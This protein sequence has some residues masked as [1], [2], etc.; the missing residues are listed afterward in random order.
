MIT[1]HTVP[2]CLTALFTCLLILA[3]CG[4]R[5]SNLDLV[6]VEEVEP[7][8]QQVT[9]VAE[10]DTFELE[11]DEPWRRVY[12]DQTQDW[13]PAMQNDA[14][15]WVLT[16]EGEA[17]RQQRMEELQ[18]REATMESLGDWR[19]DMTDV[20]MRSGALAAKETPG[21]EAKPDRRLALPEPSASDAA[22]A[23]P[24]P[25]PN[26]DTMD[27][28][29]TADMVYTA[30][31]QESVDAAIPAVEPPAEAATDPTPTLAPDEAEAIAAPDVETTTPVEPLD[32]VQ[33]MDT[34]ATTTAAPAETVAP[35]APAAPMVEPAAEALPE[36]TVT[37]DIEPTRPATTPETA[38]TTE[39]G[40]KAGM[41]DGMQTA[42]AIAPPDSMA[43]AATPVGD[44]T[45]EAVAPTWVVISVD[46]GAR[47]DLFLQ[48]GQVVEMPYARGVA[49]K[50]G[51]TQA[52]RVMVNGAYRP[53]EDA[54]HGGVIHLP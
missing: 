32:T 22:A 4:S 45:I 49:L 7:G 20:P 42:G 48:S 31:A 34:V 30:D 33:P 9:P 53:L 8:V 35:A 38:E 23:A 1:P 15:E 36:P 29:D 41:E 19:A 28:V 10:N 24:A 27:A 14:G 47:H 17:L 50:V 21:H 11:S 43:P 6:F 51:N 13:Y 52:V 25:T 39:R 5:S 16:S 37:T 26:A 18:R 54:S 12:D 44:V 40:P 2:L 3:G 46:E